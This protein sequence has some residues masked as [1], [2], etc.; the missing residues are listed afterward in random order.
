MGG[1]GDTQK[2]QQ[3]YLN[4]LRQHLETQKSQLDSHIEHITH[5]DITSASGLFKQKL[6]SLKDSIDSSNIH[7][8][9]LKKDLVENKIHQD[10]SNK[11]LNLLNDVQ[12]NI[13]ESQIKLV[14]L[15]NEFCL[16]NQPIPA[17]A[18]LQP[19]H[20]FS[21]QRTFR[22]GLLTKMKN[23]TYHAVPR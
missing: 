20:F 4:E 2:Q 17:A 23:L 5:M 21:Q 12:L 10:D 8:N 19:F 22:S 15:E 3:Q 16:K 6:K 7:L 1:V 11:I 14:N 9:S 18:I 13:N